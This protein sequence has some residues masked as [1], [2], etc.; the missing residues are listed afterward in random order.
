MKFAKGERVKLTS[1]YPVKR[2]TIPAG[3]VGRITEVLSTIF[4]YKVYFDDNFSNI[5][6]PEFDLVKA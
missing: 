4:C 3:T 6:V 2:G 1:N 5:T